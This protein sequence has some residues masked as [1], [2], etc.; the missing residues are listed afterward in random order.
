MGSKRELN[1]II[2]E[3]IETRKKDWEYFSKLL[4]E[5]YVGDKEGLGTEKVVGNKKYTLEIFYDNHLDLELIDDKVYIPLSKRI[6]Y[7]KEGKPGAKKG[8]PRKLKNLF[9]AVKKCEDSEILQL[10]DELKPKI[11]NID[12][13]E[14]LELGDKNN[15]KEINENLLKLGKLKI[16]YGEYISGKRKMSRGKTYSLLQI[17]SAIRIKPFIIFAGISGTGKTQIARIIA[18]IMSS[19]TGEK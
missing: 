14:Y 17:I 19:F 5:G 12:G 13:E 16:E 3:V 18:S 4:G 15:P 1:K 8:I 9:E 2:K 7:N 6:T 10:Y 11:K